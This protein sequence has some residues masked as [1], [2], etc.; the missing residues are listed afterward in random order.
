MCDSWHLVPTH[1]STFSEVPQSMG[2]YSQ[3]WATRIWATEVACPARRFAWS[4]HRV[5]LLFT[6]WK[7]S[8]LPKTQHLGEANDTIHW[9]LVRKPQETLLT[10]PYSDMFFM[11]YHSLG[12]RIEHLRHLP[13]Y[14]KSFLKGRTALCLS[15]SP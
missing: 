6:E 8:A 12:L 11:G 10:F 14:S 4:H 13:L 5:L 9:L 7:G 3:V 15:A 2:L 1:V